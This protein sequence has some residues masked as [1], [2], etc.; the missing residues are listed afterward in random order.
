MRIEVKQEGK[1]ASAQQG[2]QAQSSKPSSS[3]LDGFKKPEFKFGSSDRYALTL[4]TFYWAFII[5]Y[6]IVYYFT[7]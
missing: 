2:S 5:H 1:Q 7:L 6:E 4:H 3:K